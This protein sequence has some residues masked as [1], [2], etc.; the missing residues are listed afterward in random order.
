M[1]GKDSLDQ[2]ELFDGV[3]DVKG[4]LSDDSESELPKRPRG[5]LSHTDREYLWGLREYK[6][7]QSEANRKQDIRERIVHAFRDFQPLSVL[8]D[9]EER[10]KIFN[11]EID[12]ERLQDILEAMITFVYLG[13]G[14]DENRLE[15]IVENG[16]YIGA[17]FDK[18]G[19]W[20]GEATDVDVSIDIEYNPD[21]DDLYRRLEE[22]GGDQLTPAEIGVLVQSGK[23]DET[24]LD[25]LEETQP[26][27]PGVFAGGRDESGNDETTETN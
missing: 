22:G 8:L 2:D 15:K 7:A 1:D 21:V 23:L 11:E 9:A 5:I 24:D 19:R 4:S 27:Y 18:S 13:L 6:H 17:N 20:A 25:E 16:V 3:E 10:G 12:E 14:Q 26:T